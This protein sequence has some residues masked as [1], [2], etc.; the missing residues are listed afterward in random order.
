MLSK[1]VQNLCS[2]YFCLEIDTA[3]NKLGFSVDEITK[4]NN[5]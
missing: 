3:S 1:P 4:K 5:V 2:R